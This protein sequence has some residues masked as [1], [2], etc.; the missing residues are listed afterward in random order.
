[1]CSK[2]VE[3]WN[4]L[5]IKFSASSCL[6]LR[7]KKLLFLHLVRWLYCISD[8]R[9]RKHQINSFTLSLTRSHTPS[10]KWFQKRT[11]SLFQHWATNFSPCNQS[12]RDK[13]PIALSTLRT[14]KERRLQSNLSQGWPR[15]YKMI[16]RLLLIIRS[17]VI[18]TLYI[19][20]DFKRLSIIYHDA[21][22]M[23]LVVGKKMLYLCAALTDWSVLRIL[24]SR[25]WGG[26]YPHR[27]RTKRNDLFLEISGFKQGQKKQT[28]M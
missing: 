12:W 11:Q 9:S 4:K 23:C 5:I 6:I 10:T 3:A 25:L 27:W 22:F 18:A 20:P 24:I 1:M 2:H 16:V 14:S 8:A 28:Y 13:N 19:S 15:S 21:Y 26:S 17:T 7:N